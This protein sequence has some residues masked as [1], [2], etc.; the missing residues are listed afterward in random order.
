MSTIKLDPERIIKT[1]DQLE[2]R[3]T[4]RFPE[5]GLRKVCLEFLYVSQK[6]KKRIEW[7]SKPNL[8]LRLFSYLILLIGIGGLVYSISYVELTIKDTT[9]VNIVTLSEAIFNDILLLGAAVF[10][11]VT[12]ETRQ[13]RKKALAAL[14]ELRTIAHVVDM[15]QLTKDPSLSENNNKSTEHS[16]KRT[17][18]K[19]ELQRYLNY[20]SELSALIAKTASLY[21]QSFPDEVIINGV[22][23]IEDLTTGL[24]RKV[25]QKI[26]ILNEN[27]NL[28]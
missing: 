23:E 22:N 16:P 26:M 10:F 21:S 27:T 8:S 9:L 24:S 13:K 15:H 3:I 14:N 20:C 28:D 6:T 17:L 5:S 12:I 4:D 25:W 18:T 7:I 19:F 1:I 2:Q 11:L